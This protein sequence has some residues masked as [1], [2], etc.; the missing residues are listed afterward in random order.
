MVDQTPDFSV[1][2]L[3]AG[4]AGSVVSLRF[5]QGT[6]A[7]RIFMGI[8]GASLSYY[9]TTPAAQW[10]GVKDAEG[11]VG[12]LIGLFGMAIMAKI[13]EVI[14]VTDAKQIS[15]DAWSAL[16]RKLGA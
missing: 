3:L 5:V 7:E 8:G 11:L 15:A 6:V 10:V 1:A 12:F 4:L 14:L 16:K 13:Y 2:K 9:A